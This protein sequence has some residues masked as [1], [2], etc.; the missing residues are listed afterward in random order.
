MSKFFT[1]LK[2]KWYLLPW[3]NL[4]PRTDVVRVVCA[5]PVY[6]RY[7]I[8]TTAVGQCHS[9]DKKKIILTKKL[10]VTLEIKY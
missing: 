10:Q 6:I 1:G 9:V 8:S 2:L 3:Q 7:R 5:R 4:S